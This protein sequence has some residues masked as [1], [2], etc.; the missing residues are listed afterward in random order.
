[1][2]FDYMIQVLWCY[3]R[4]ENEGSIIPSGDKVG[5][6]ILKKC[7][8]TRV[9]NEGMAKVSKNNKNKYFHTVYQPVF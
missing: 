5:E 8:L 4:T 1:M 9:T 6:L 7:H 3:G 2:S